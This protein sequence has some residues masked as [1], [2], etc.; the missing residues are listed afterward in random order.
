MDR[1]GP[2]GKA[3]GG[4]NRAGIGLRVV[5]MDLERAAAVG[6]GSEDVQIQVQVE[7][8]DLHVGHAGAKTIPAPAAVLE[9]PD[10][11]IATEIE[12][13]V[14]RIDDDLPEWNVV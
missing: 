12:R 5:E 2:G 1:P 14:A 10:A 3:R 4:A 7:F 9:P 11:L 13:A 6:A 8:L